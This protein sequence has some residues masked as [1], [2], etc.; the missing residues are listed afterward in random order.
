MFKF[1]VIF[2]FS[3]YRYYQY[4]RSIRPQKK[5]KKTLVRIDRNRNGPPRRYE[6]RG[7]NSTRL[8]ATLSD[9]RVGRKHAYASLSPPSPFLLKYLFFRRASTSGKK[10][11]TK[12]ISIVFSPLSVRNL[13]IDVTVLR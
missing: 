1:I 9:P 4:D 8:K 6:T 7:L 3:V 11:K 12:P 5:K 13:N 10:K 2:F